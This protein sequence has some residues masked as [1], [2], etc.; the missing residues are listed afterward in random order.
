MSTQKSPPEGDPGKLA[1]FRNPNWTGTP[2]SRI[3]N[4]DPRVCPGCLFAGSMKPTPHVDDERCQH[5]RAR[6]T[7]AEIESGRYAK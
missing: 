7:A 3:E 6:Q 2:R 5:F 1:Y 4:I